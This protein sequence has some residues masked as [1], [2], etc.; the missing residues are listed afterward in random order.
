MK[1]FKNAE[2]VELYTVSKGSVTNWVNS[3]KEKKINLELT[4]VRGKSYILNTPKNRILLQELSNN[5]KKFKKR[6]YLKTISPDESF[7]KVFNKKQAIEIINNLDVYHEIPNK[8]SYFNGGAKFWDSY[9]NK[10]LKE[11]ASPKSSN[12]ATDTIQL[13]KLNLDYILTLIEE[14]EFVN[15]ID[16]G[17]GNAVPV[18]DL[19]ELLITKKKLR[20]YIGI[21]FSKEMIDIAE[22]NLKGWFGNDFEIEKHIKDISREGF[23]EIIYENT[24]F[25][26]KNKSSVNLVVFLGSTLNNERLPTYTLNLIKE[27]LGKSDI[28]IFGQRLDTD[29]SKI[30]FDMYSGDM[31]TTTKPSTL[32]NLDKWILDLLNISEDLYDVEEVYSE[33]ERSRYIRILLKVDLK[34][35]F[36]LEG[37]EQTV[38]FNKGDRIIL[39]RY[40]HQT[41]TEATNEMVNTGFNILHTSTSMSNERVLIISNLRVPSKKL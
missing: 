33:Q 1:Y 3:A 31:S 13:M 26:N 34:I 11:K 29:H 39:W 10:L 35:V 36:K 28:F 8:Y 16:I 9:I 15:V 41:Y 30:S 37:I 32:D 21:E 25:S 17:V 7:Y 18:K 19:L 14:Y 23:E 38:S 40:R 22:N 2:I 4:D 20:K 27:S 12:Y 24:H 6:K 5:G